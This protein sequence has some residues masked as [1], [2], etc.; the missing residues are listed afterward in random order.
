[1]K[2]I[3]LENVLLYGAG[4]LAL[5]IVLVFLLVFLLVRSS[6]K[7]KKKIVKKPI[8]NSGEFNKNVSINSNLM[9]KKPQE[10]GGIINRNI[11]SKATNSN[12]SPVSWG[13]TESYEKE[14]QKDPILKN[15]NT[16]ISSLIAIEEKKKENVVKNDN[17]D[18]LILTEEKRNIKPLILLVDDSMTILKFTSNILGKNG[19][20]VVTKPDGEE[21]LTY[22]RD[23]NN[24]KPD[25]ILSD[26]EMPKMNGIELI[27]KIRQDQKYNKIPIMIISSHAESHLSLMTDGLIQGFMH[28]P[29]KDFELLEQLKYLLNK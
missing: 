3:V 22:L 18:D 19:Y 12:V 23:N 29:F 6:K 14:I 2:N 21:A 8:K 7:N 10:T 20:D 24:I 16:T 4:G 5:T 9:E 27:Q 13:M 11:E 28:K 15:P 25:L 26:I 1:M 17:I